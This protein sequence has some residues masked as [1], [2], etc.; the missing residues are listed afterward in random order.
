MLHCDVIWLNWFCD[1]M[2]VVEKNHLASKIA[3]ESASVT[4]HRALV[5]C[6]LLPHQL[7]KPGYY[8]A[9]HILPVHHLQALSGRAVFDIEALSFHRLLLRPEA[10]YNF[11]SEHYSSTNNIVTSHKLSK[12]CSLSLFTFLL[13]AR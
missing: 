3:S 2:G 4:E 6:F 8:T 12:C 10:C 1:K 7:R 5:G 11:E 9:S 13:L